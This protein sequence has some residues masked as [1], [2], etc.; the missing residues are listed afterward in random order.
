MN[1]NPRHFSLKTKLTLSFLLLF[2]AV[3]TAFYWY[4]RSTEN[5]LEAANRLES[6]AET[7]QQEI[8]ECTLL[9]QQQQGEFSRFQY[10][11]RLL[12]VFHS[13]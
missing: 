7:L 12:E 11:S 13:N 3:L 9:M 4:Y 2:T 5:K 6:Q 8:D 10:C 1:I